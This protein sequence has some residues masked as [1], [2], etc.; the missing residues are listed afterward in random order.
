M[1]AGRPAFA[2]LVLALA[3]A[4]APPAALESARA[5]GTRLSAG[6]RAEAEIERRALDPFSGTWRS[7]RGRVTLE[8]PDR[9]LLEFPATGE[10][11]A[12]RGDGG[13]WLQPGLKQMLRL[14]PGNAAAARRWWELLL[15]A[16]GARFREVALGGRRFAL[17]PRDAEAGGD[18]AWIALDPRGL[19]A[20]LEYQDEAGARIEY[21]LRGWRFPRA[22][23]RAGFVIAAP[24]SYQVVELP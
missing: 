24:D 15:P 11:I 5:L 17:V 18:T 9:A 16:G 12:L 7:V 14:G 13:E 8:P 23:G 22:R 4:A 21:R 10:R 6:G 2:A 3:C 20:R 19:P 1:R